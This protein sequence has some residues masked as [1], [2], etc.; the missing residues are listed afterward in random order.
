MC[1]AAGSPHIYQL[2][3]APSLLPEVSSWGLNDGLVHPGVHYAD[4]GKGQQHHDEEVGNQYIVPAVV[5]SLPHLSGT[6]LK[7]EGRLRPR[8]LLLV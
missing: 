8:W 5:H 7:D 3:I 2:F 6:D 4:E 1:L